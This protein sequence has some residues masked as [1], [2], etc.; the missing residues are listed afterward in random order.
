MIKNETASFFRFLHDLESVD[1][2]TSSNFI[3]G[4]DYVMDTVKNAIFGDPDIENMYDLDNLI[5]QIDSYTDD[6]EGDYAQGY[7]EAVSTC[8]EAVSLLIGSEEV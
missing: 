2:D 3:E 7:Q 5:N 8:L 6:F 1:G 4:Y